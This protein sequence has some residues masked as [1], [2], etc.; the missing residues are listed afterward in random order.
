MSTPPSGQSLRDTAAVRNKLR[1]SPR[2]RARDEEQPLFSLEPRARLYMSSAITLALCFAAAAA[3]PTGRSP[4]DRS[5]GCSVDSPAKGDS[6]AEGETV[7]IAWSG[8]G[9]PTEEIQIMLTAGGMP[10]SRIAASAAGSSFDWIVPSDVPYEGQG[11][12]RTEISAAAGRSAKSK[13]FDITA[14]APAQ[15]METLGRENTTS[16]NSTV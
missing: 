5:G 14:E 10:Q 11:A 8:D 7:H 3:A 2:T 6:Y 16:F 4:V 9:C 12:F 15:H 13:P 1:V